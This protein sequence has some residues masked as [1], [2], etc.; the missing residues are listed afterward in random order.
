MAMTECDAQTEMTITRY[1]LAVPIGWAILLG[2][3]PV[4]FLMVR[5]GP[6]LWGMLLLAAGMVSAGALISTAG[7]WR[8]RETRRVTLHSIDAGTKD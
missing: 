2:E 7:P 6:S 8:T 3:L 1:N 4:A 5:H